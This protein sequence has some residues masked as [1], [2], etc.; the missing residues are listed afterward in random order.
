MAQIRF[1]AATRDITPDRPVLLH[2]YA[3]RD[4]LAGDRPEDRVSEPLQGGALCLEGT[5]RR[6]GRRRVCIVTL[7]TI[8]VQ[9]A[10]D[11]ALR[12]AAAAA[13]GI[14]PSDIL[15]CSSHTHFAPAISEQIFSSP[16]V[17]IAGADARFAA[18]LTARVA[19]AVRESVESLQEGTLEEYRVSVP[20]VLF[21]RRTVVKGSNPRR[22]ETSFL[23]PD[24]PS[25]YEFSA[26][27][28][29]LTALRFTTSLGP[30]AV[31]CNFGCHPVTG[32]RSQEQF[33]SVSSDYPWYLR[34]S[35]RDA[36]GCP[37][38]FSLGAAGDSVPMLRLGQAREQIGRTLASAL[39]LGERAFRASGG[40][41]GEAVVDS[42]T[43]GLEA[44]TILEVD[45]RGA[46]RD[47]E[48]SRQKALS[49]L[50]ASDANREARREAVLKDFGEK[51]LR[52]FRARLYQA[53][54]FRVEVQL[55]RIG[56][57]V[58]VALPFE[59]LSE[60]SLRI[61][62]AFPQAAVVSVANGYEGYLPLAHEYTRGGYEATV[63]STHFEPGTA[64]RV[65]ELILS[66]LRDF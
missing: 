62:S 45:A 13:S 46:E 43:V 55:L 18:S 17:G 34:Q 28:S 56:Q 51:M 9:A 6:G 58:L 40:T 10:Q 57:T 44:R 48:E 12:K 16:A 5:G 59:V 23:Y 38:F 27:D 4:R 42:R 54:R 25:G 31:F 39:L 35:I 52:A 14:A 64:D 19:E 66:E 26:V 24:Q 63:E 11:A 7:D 22:V 65:L 1:G 49:L 15:I 60:I 2:G 61:K 33:Y 30:R 29:Q 3:A 53:N 21:N 41:D 50:D 37:T 20:S 32:G 8:G 36:W 47:Y